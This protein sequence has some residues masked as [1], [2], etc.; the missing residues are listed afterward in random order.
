LDEARSMSQ[1]LGLRA[2]SASALAALGDVLLA[3]DKLPEAESSYRESLEIGRQL[4]DRDGVAWS[5]LSLAELAAARGDFT[6]AEATAQEI[7]N[8]F[9]AQS[10]SDVE[11]A[12]RILLAKAF[13]AEGK[14]DAAEMDLKAAAQ[15]DAKDQTAKLNW[16]IADGRLLAREGR[17]REA[18][19]VLTQALERAKKMGYVPGEFEARLAMIEPATI[20]ESGSGGRRGTEIDELVHDA[21]AKGFY[22][23][24]RRAKQAGAK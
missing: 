21:E 20:E 13:T 10:N 7:A 15:L 8:D 17:K 4:G 16:S 3:E 22:R 5:R 6:G 19:Q 1:S 2:D 24:A 12:A 14:L 18:A 23:V 11:M 9:H